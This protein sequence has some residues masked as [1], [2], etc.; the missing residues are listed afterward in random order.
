MTA[1]APTV[2]VVLAAYNG[3]ALIG[4]TLR[5][6]AAQT[7]TDWEA[8]VVDDAS[9]DGTA[10][11]VRAW[12]DPRV[13]LIM[14]ERN[15]GC[16]AAR[17]RAVEAA[18]G[19]YLAG[20]D[21]DD[22]CHPERFARQVAYLDRHPDVVLAGTAASAL[23]A[24]RVRPLAHAAHTS[25][26]LIEW[27]LRIENP[28]VWSST[29]IRGDA[30]RALV[31]FERQELL[32][33]EDFDLYHRLMQFG[34]IARLDEALVTYRQHGG[35]MSQRGTARMLDQAGRV[36]AAAYAPLLGA[37]ADAAG[38]LVA[39]H[40]M[41]QVP[42]PDRATLDQLGGLIAR[43]QADFLGSTAP[44]AADVRLIR[45]ET[46]RRWARIGRA[47][48]RSGAIGLPDA[49]SVRPD[50]VG[51]GYAGPG[52]LAWHRMVAGAKAVRAALR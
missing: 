43:L 38:A 10:E 23:S 22:L 37:G 34:R 18:R 4:D 32:Y 28:I 24:G 39:R 51:L 17:N 52:E 7:L 48:L 35:G 25:P 47:A 6:L 1:S 3:A 40:V 11:L 14:A 31:P 50:H 16:V 15:G 5:S 27:L 19:R 49:L 46:A 21:H 29:M 8:V 33:A 26:A 2:S 30:A 44:S 13:R 12:P 41:G 9:T 36:L 20:L 42:V 45:W